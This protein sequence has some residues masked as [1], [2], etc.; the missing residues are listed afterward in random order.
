MGQLSIVPSFISRSVHSPHQ[1]M[2]RS[3]FST[4]APPASTNGN[5]AA[6]KAVASQE[7]FK[8]ELE[9]RKAE[10]EKHFDAATFRDSVRGFM[11]HYYS[12]PAP[13][14]VSIGHL[15]CN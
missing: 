6:A 5:N 4:V 11:Q 14:L 8:A 12:K 7:S 3:L 9:A 1:L 13:Q 15:V 10:F 2:Q